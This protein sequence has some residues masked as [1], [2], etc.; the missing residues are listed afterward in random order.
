M[1][2]GV[3]GGGIATTKWLVKHGA[4]VTVTDLRSR[5]QL[6]DSIKK[7]GPVVKKVKLILGEHRESDFKTND[8]I[9][10]NPAVPRE[11]KYL[12]VARKHKKIIVNDARI[13]FDS[14]KNP[15]MAITGTRGKTTTTNW[16][17]HFL[18]SK[19]PRTVAAGNSSDVAL[20]TLTERLKNQETPAII[21]LSSWQLELLPSAKRA[22]DVAVIT[23]IYPDHLNRY[24]SLNDYALAKANIFK[25]Q[26]KNQ[27]LILNAENI[28]T[29]FFL[30]QHPRSRIF[31]FSKKPL[32]KNQNGI[33]TKNKTIY[34]KDGKKITKV[35]P[36]AIFKKFITRGEHNLENLMTALIAGY[37]MGVSWRMS[38]ER[39][40]TLPD[41]LYREQ[42]ILR[43][44]NLT[45]VNDSTATSPDAVIAAVKRF[46]PQEG[47][48]I[49]ITGGTDKN[50]DFRELAKTLKKYLKPEQV[51]FLNGSATKR[52][53]RELKKSGYFRGEK[54]N[55]R[56]DLGGILKDT[57]RL[58]R[59]N[60]NIKWTIVFSPGAASFEKFNNEFDRGAKFSKYAKE[61]FDED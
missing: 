30:K 47:K 6:K 3:L 12:G 13:F 37:F 45:V 28:W 22:P 44:K 43:K 16:I 32:S 53:I 56:E 46:S 34:F 19:H 61:I 25:E 17:A 38:V 57:T 31:F 55:L 42:V 5:E 11:S 48:I 9:V 7:L 24:K 49:L 36:E 1:G 52:L 26:N 54:I 29:N 15:I 23:N 4:K 14:V 27:K 50:L 2:L 20:L 33:F 39:I 41:I 35:V 21:E 58:I 18:R 10:V 60:K 40:K 51:Y 59:K 8:M